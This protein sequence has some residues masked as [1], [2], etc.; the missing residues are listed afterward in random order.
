MNKPENYSENTYSPSTTA[1][2]RG[3]IALGINLQYNSFIWGT[4]ARMIYDHNPVYKSADGLVAGTGVSY[5]FLQSSISLSYLFS[6]TNVWNHKDF[7]GVKLD[8]GDYI[9]TVI[10]S[11]RYK[12]SE[13]TGLFM[14]AGLTDTTPFFAV[15]LRTGF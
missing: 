1:D 9:H 4:S 15:G 11:F 5:D 3:Q 14:S 13:E 2:W 10:A 12:Y 7:N 8:D 6:D